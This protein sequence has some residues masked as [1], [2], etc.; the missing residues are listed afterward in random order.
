[1][2]ETAYVYRYLGG[3]TC[4]SYGTLPSKN[5]ACVQETPESL[6]CI[7]VWEFPGRPRFW[8]GSRARSAGKGNEERYQAKLWKGAKR[9][10]SGAK[11]I[12]L[13]RSTWTFGFLHLPKKSRAR[14][15]K[16]CVCL[17]DREVSSKR[18]H[19]KTSQCRILFAVWFLVL[20][21][22]SLVAPVDFFYDAVCCGVRKA[23]K[24]SFTVPKCSGCLPA[25]PKVYQWSLNLSK[26]EVR[27]GARIYWYS[28]L[29]LNNNTRVDP[30]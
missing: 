9:L 30:S 14:A 1:M 6:G 16:V 27:H 7:L 25:S 5:F 26:I 24:R 17:R 29:I 21:S 22:T 4:F 18:R 13:L 2:T 3:I 12:R 11:K 20:C 10:C 23:A 8:S 28:L 19:A 15:H